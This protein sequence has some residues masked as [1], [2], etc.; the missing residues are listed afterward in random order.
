[1]DE[2]AKRLTKILQHDVHL[3]AGGG[4]ERV[5]VRA[6]IADEPPRMPLLAAQPQRRRTDVQ[7]GVATQAHSAEPAL[8]VG[9]GSLLIDESQHLA[10]VRLPEAHRQQEDGQPCNQARHAD[11]A[12]RSRGLV[13]ACSSKRC[14]R[15][16]SSRSTLHP[17][18]VSR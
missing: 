7:G 14:R 12:L 18:L 10:T 4:W 16:T 1:M 8:I 11:P 2:E 9:F 3:S 6:R 17:G 13:W 15:S 5:D